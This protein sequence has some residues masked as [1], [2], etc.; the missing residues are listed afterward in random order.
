MIG[1]AAFL[2]S[3]EFLNGFLTQ[4]SFCGFPGSLTVLGKVESTT[5]FEDDSI[6]ILQHF[7]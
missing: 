1:V 3:F 7:A 4:K 6:K 5:C 2:E